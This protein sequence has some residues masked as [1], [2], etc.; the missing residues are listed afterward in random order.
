MSHC[1][2]KSDMIE[3]NAYSECVAETCEVCNTGSFCGG[4]LFISEICE[5]WFAFRNREYR[6]VAERWGMENHLVEPPP[7]SETDH[8]S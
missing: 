6:E 2:D 4:S 3:Y 8:N 1:L 5:E 7:L